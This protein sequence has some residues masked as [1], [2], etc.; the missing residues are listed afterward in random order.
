[1]RSLR[2]ISRPYAPC[3]TAKKFSAFGTNAPRR[4]NFRNDRKKEGEGK[5]KVNPLSPTARA[6][7]ARAVGQLPLYAEQKGGAK[8]KVRGFALMS[9]RPNGVGGGIPKKECVHSGGFLGLT[10]LA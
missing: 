7:S 4:Q 8:G 10:R 3:L 9:S 2:G 6:Q 1:M 5:N